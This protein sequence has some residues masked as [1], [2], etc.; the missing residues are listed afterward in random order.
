M[1]RTVKTLVMLAIVAFSWNALASDGI[2]LKVNDEQHLIV[3]VENIESSAV[4]T[5]LDIQ[6][7]VIF[8]EQFPAETNYSKILNL[9]QL[10]DGKYL[11]VLDKKFSRST[12]TIIKKGREVSVD[13]TAYAV[14]MKP[15]FKLENETLSLSMSN[16]K[17]SKTEIE[18][19]DSSGDRLEKVNCKDLVVKKSFNFSNVRPG[20]YT[21]IVKT[22]EETF[23]E[24]F[25]VG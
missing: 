10:N 20:K 4:L 23:T 1:K 15:T 6:G 2:N 24:T 17:G 22:A 19:Y 8:K 11:L 3:D 25:D 14:V 21:V 12:S 18:I 9:V 5:L 7:N 16:A 13:T